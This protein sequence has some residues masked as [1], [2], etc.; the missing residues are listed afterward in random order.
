MGEFRYTVFPCCEELTPQGLLA[1][2]HPTSTLSTKSDN[3]TGLG[4]K[5]DFK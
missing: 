1:T 3:F 2:T 4:K 5:T